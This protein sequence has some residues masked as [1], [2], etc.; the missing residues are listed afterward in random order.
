MM[1]F[2]LKLE[3]PDPSR[4]WISAAV[5]GMAYFLGGIIPMIPY[6]AVKHVNTALFISI[7]ITVIILLI[8][9][10]SKSI[11]TGTGH[12]SAAFSAIQTLIVGALA[13]GASYGIVR[14]V[15]ASLG[16]MGMST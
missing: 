7:V 9:G 10:Y 2:K 6:F 4:A 8:F 12:K 13:A 3:K 5:M 16:G 11:I 15:N 1:D 14:G